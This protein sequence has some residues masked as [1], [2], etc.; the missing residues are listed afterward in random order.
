MMGSFFQDIRYALRTLTQKPGFTIIAVLTLALGIGATTAMFSV[1]DAVLL[2]PLPFRSQEQLIRANG[3]F[4]LSEEAAVSPPDFADYRA[5]AKS[6]QQFA[7]LG[8]LDGISNVTGGAQP[9]QVRSQIVSWN[10]FEALGISPLV[11]RSFVA[12]DEKVH[13][14]QVVILGN[15]IWKR[16][17]GGD[18]AIIGRKVAL[19]GDSVTVVGVLPVDFPSLSTAEVWMPL[20]MDNPGMNMRQAHF[21][22][23]IARMKPGIDITAARTEL[24]SVAGNIAAQNPDTN[25]GWSLRVVS[26]TNFVVGGTQKALI[27]LLGAVILL[28]LIGCAN[29]ANL[30]LA[31]AAGRRKEIAIRS[32][33]G[34]GRWRIAR[35]LLTESLVLSVAG[36]TLGIFIAIWGVAGLSALAPSSLPRVN[37]IQVNFT[38]L[39][40]AAGISLLTGILFGLAPAIQFSRGAVQQELKEGARGSSRTASHRTG[41]FL[42][43][44]EVALS[45]ALLL[46]GALLFNSF[47]RLIHVDPGFRSDHVIATTLHMSNSARPKNQKAPF[48]HALEEKLGSLP[49]V[50]GVGAISEL[51]LSGQLNDNSFQIEGKIYPKGHGDDADFR[52]VTSGLLSALRIPVISGRWFNATD[53]ATSPGTVVVNQEFARQFFGKNNPAGNHI[54][55]IGDSVKTREIVGVIE[56]IKHQSLDETPRAAMYI[57]IDQS[58]PPDMNLVVRSSGNPLQLASALRDEVRAL[59]P[60]QA[61][62]TIR[63][64][65][66][67]VSGSVAQPRFASQILGLFAVLALLLAAVGLYGLIAYTVSQRTHEIGIRMALGAEPRDVLKLVIG[68]GLK[69]ALAGAAIGIA[70][71]LALTRLMQGLLFQVSP[72]D[73]V[74]F[75][76]VT[77]LLTIVALAASYLPARRAM[78]VDPMIALRYE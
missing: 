2:R 54:S 66:E 29:V 9:E 68:Q 28:L 61:I 44:G 21:L 42:V 13:D 73:P 18:T 56:T 77:A 36:G 14:P 40:F 62:S 64:M 37:D 20:P 30:L 12:A 59:D 5:G 15:G 7:A 46:G 53:T 47:W 25:K 50:E 71:A 3:K 16:D 51:P 10:F 57:L 48:Y 78:R 70:G 17:F 31:R 39:A 4:L 26:L 69:L 45:I 24:D 1:V 23:V 35:Q 76:G 49:G 34:A 6:F 33:L 43:I 52:Q 22:A 65:D 75:I 38:V 67:I 58:A 41:N 55:I 11:G 74:T 63:S 8:Y 32:A 19:D 72:T 60:N 27:L